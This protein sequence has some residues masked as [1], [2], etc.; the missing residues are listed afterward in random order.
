MNYHYKWFHATSA[1]AGIHFFKMEYL[2]RHLICGYVFQDGHISQITDVNVIDFELD[3]DMIHK[4][5]EARVTDLAGRTTHIVGT[6]F[7]HQVYF[8][9]DWHGPDG[10]TARRSSGRRGLVT[11]ALC[12]MSR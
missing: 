2:G 10:T 11:L 4:N 12:C 8:A 1:E 3:A 6:H 7:A 5:I 9:L